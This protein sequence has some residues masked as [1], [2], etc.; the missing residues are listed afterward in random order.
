MLPGH[1]LPSFDEER[2]CHDDHHDVGIDGNRKAVLRCG[3]ASHEDFV[4]GAEECPDEDEDGSHFKHV[5]AGAHGDDNADHADRDSVPSLAA[6]VFFE[7]ECGEEDHEEGGSIAK[8]I[9]D[10][11][12]S[13]GESVHE[14]IGVGEVNGEAQDMA[15]RVRGAEDFADAA[16]EKYCDEERDQSGKCA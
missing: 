5:G 1:G 3:E 16:L 2:K 15:L 11:Q 13:H 12:R 6:D 8:C 9:D 10:G 7:H 14:R 4:E